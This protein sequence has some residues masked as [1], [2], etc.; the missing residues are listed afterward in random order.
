[1][2]VFTY[3]S[4]DRAIENGEGGYCISVNG[5]RI[6][7]PTACPEVVSFTNPDDLDVDLLN[8]WKNGERGPEFENQKLMPG[9]CLVLYDNG[10]DLNQVINKDPD[11]YKTSEGIKSMIDMLYAYADVGGKNTEPAIWNSDLHWA[12]GVKLTTS[13]GELITKDLWKEKSGLP[14]KALKAPIKQEF[15]HV[16]P[17]DKLISPKGI[18]Q[19]AAGMSAIAVKQPDNTWNMVQLN[20]K[21]Y[22][23]VDEKNNKQLNENVDSN[24]DWL[25]I[26]KDALTKK[27]KE[28][29]GKTANTASGEVDDN[30]R[31][32]AKQQTSIAKAI[33]LSKR[34]SNK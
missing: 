27:L 23:V 11:W 31:K 16:S 24:I 30:A 34:Q 12:E 2:T 25:E 19:T 9:D 28:R 26:K 5:A 10:R 14:I 13:N 18:I 7:I 21:G 8:R 17:G 3:S 22:V 6:I 32:I 29:L 4:L 1:M 20:A 33:M 15:I